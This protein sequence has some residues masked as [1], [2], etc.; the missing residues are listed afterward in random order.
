MPAYPP[1]AGEFR[2]FHQRTA[3]GI[4]R[5][6]TVPVIKLVDNLVD[7]C[8]RPPPAWLDKALLENWASR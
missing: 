8:R 2:P 5:L 1:I 3:P 6:L 7:K 4:R